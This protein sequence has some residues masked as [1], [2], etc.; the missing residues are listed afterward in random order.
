MRGLL[1]YSAALISKENVV[2]FATIVICLVGIF[3]LLPY[4]SLGAPPGPILQISAPTQVP[5]GKRIEIQLTA[6]GVPEIAGLEL[7]LPFDTARADF[8]GAHCHNNALC[9]LGRDVNDLIA[10]EPGRGS[11]PVSTTGVVV[12]VGSGG[13]ARPAPSGSYTLSNAP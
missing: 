13:R 5:L 10:P 6:V 1:D 4:A 12:Q 7:N 2:R 11:V 8:N 9:G 3:V